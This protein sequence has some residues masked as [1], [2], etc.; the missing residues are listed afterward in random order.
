M[1]SDDIVLKLRVT[2]PIWVDEA[3][4][5]PQVRAV[6]GTYYQDLKAHEEGHKAI[7][8]DA[9]DRINKITHQASAA[10]ACDAF[11]QSLD[12]AARQIA[13]AAEGAQDEHDAEAKPFA[14]E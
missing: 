10:G 6:W 8:V 11:R 7:A 13:E 3:R 14:L 12:S 9:A 4:A 2:L 5:D 1:T